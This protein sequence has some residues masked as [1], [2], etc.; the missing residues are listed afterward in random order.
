MWCISLWQ[1]WASLI[2]IGAKKIETRSWRAAEKHIGTVIGIHAAKTDGM[3]SG[4]GEWAAAKAFEQ[5]EY[6][7]P[8]DLRTLPHG[9]I[10][11]VARLVDCVRMHEGNGWTELH[12]LARLCDGTTIDPPER[13]FGDYTP[14]RWAWK[15]DEV[16]ALAK[17]VPLRGR[18]QLF[19]VDDSV[20][21][22]AVSEPAGV[23]P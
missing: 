16:R 19:E 9:A 8:L 7:I 21:L 4:S 23:T 6:P 10:I 5:A 17:P 15:L 13:F 22:D 2:A 3:L 20:I 14:G 12:G 1:P 11:A 18:Q